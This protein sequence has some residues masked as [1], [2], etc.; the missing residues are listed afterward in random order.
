MAELRCT[1]RPHYRFQVLRTT[2]VPRPSRPA[3]QLEAAGSHGPRPTEV[4]ARPHLHLHPSP[5]TPQGG[6]SGQ[7]C[8]APDR[9]VLSLTALS[10]VAPP[11]RPCSQQL[12]S[13]TYLRAPPSFLIAAILHSRLRPSSCHGPFLGAADRL[14]LLLQPALR[15]T[16]ASRGCSRTKART[17]PPHKP[18]TSRLHP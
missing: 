6:S 1:H 13:R 15:G 16:E 8:S 9:A 5:P 17:R 18:A 14:G 4:S 7:P 3:L 12:P 2:G 11:A 10:G